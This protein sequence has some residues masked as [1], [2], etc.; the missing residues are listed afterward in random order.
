MLAAGGGALPLAVMESDGDEEPEVGARHALR[1]RHAHDG[2]RAGGGGVEQRGPPQHVYR[3]AV[4][5]V[6]LRAGQRCQVGAT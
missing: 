5:A 2:T 3:P 4:R 6:Q 1:V